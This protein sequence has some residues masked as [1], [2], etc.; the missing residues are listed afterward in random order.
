MNYLTTDEEQYRYSKEKLPELELRLEKQ[1][2]KIKN[3]QEQS[4]VTIGKI[5]RHASIIKIYET[6]NE[7]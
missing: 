4:K 5:E 6:E 2:I 1:I 7:C 3:K